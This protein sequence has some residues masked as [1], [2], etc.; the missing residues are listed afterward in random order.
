[1]QRWEP[2]VGE[3]R[4]LR[5]DFWLG[6]W[7]WIALK[8]FE[9]LNGDLT[10]KEFRDISVA[11]GVATDKTLL[12]AGMPTQIIVGVHEHRLQLPALLDKMRDVSAKLSARG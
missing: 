4:A 8:A 5:K 2:V 3:L 12:L 10:A 9:R 11:M 1:M 7:Q 6:A